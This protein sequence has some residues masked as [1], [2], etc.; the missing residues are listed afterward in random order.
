MAAPSQL[1]RFLANSTARYA[2]GSITRFLASPG[3]RSLLQ[4]AYVGE[5]IADKLPSFRTE[6]SP[7]HSSA[8]PFSVVLR[9]ASSH[10]F[11]VNLLRAG[12]SWVA[13]PLW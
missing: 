10:S 9:E 7:G 2:P 4:V 1:S 5:T 13:L 12:Q 3:V 6:S 8:A 11:K